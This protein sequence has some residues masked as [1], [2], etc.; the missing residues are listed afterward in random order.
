[1]GP[2]LHQVSILAAVTALTNG[3]APTAQPPGGPT[4]MLGEFQWLR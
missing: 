1:M 4:P 2:I 3:P